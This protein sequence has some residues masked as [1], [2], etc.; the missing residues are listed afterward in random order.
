MATVLQRNSTS[1]GCEAIFALFYPLIDL[2]ST[3]LSLKAGVQLGRG[4]KNSPS[5][6]LNNSYTVMETLLYGHSFSKIFVLSSGQICSPNMLGHTILQQQQTQTIIAEHQI[7]PIL[8][9]P[10]SLVPYFLLKVL[11]ANNSCMTLF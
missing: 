4:N 3:A 11:M 6:F 5:S 2:E 7:I 8:R 10:E 9:H 1:F